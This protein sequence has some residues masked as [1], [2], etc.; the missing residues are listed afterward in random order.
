ML[1]GAVDA[2]Q[3]DRDV[4]RMLEI[5]KGVVQHVEGESRRPSAEAVEMQV[6]DK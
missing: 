3:R 2:E 1:F 5:E 6:Q 4:G